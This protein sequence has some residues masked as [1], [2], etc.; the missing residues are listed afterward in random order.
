MGRLYTYVLLL[1]LVLSNLTFISATP[2]SDKDHDGIQDYSDYCPDTFMHVQIDENGCSWIQTDADDDGIVNEYDKCPESASNDCSPF[3]WMRYSANPDSSILYCSF[4]EF[5]SSQIVIPCHSHDGSHGAGT[6]GGY[7]YNLTDLTLD[8]ILPRVTKSSYSPKSD[9]LAVMVSGTQNPN[10]KFSIYEATNLNLLGEFSANG[11]V[12]GFKWNNSGNDVLIEINRGGN[13]VGFVQKYLVETNEII[14]LSTPI[15]DYENYSSTIDPTSPSASLNWPRISPNGEISY[16]LEEEEIDGAIYPAR[17]LVLEYTNN[18]STEVFYPSYRESRI[19][20]P[21]FK[22]TSDIFA[23]LKDG[24][25]TTGVFEIYIGDYDNDG[26]NFL[27]DQCF[28]TGFGSAVDVFGCST[29]QLDSDGDLVPNSVDI[30]PETIHGEYV[31]RFGCSWSESDY[32]VDGYENRIDVCPRFASYS[33]DIN[34]TIC[35]HSDYWIAEQIEPR[36]GVGYVYEFEISP[37]NRYVAVKDGSSPLKWDSKS[38]F[39]LLSLDSM[40]YMLDYDNG[41]QHLG[42]SFQFAK[43]SSTLYVLDDSNLKIYDM[44]DSLWEQNENTI[45]LNGFCNP[46]TCNFGQMDLTPN[47]SHLLLTTMESYEDGGEDNYCGFSMLNLTSFQFD[48][49][50]DMTDRNRFGSCYVAPW[51]SSNSHG[52]QVFSLSGGYGVQIHNLLTTN[53]TSLILEEIV[54]SDKIMAHSPNGNYF[55]H[56]ADGPEGTF[57]HKLQVRY[58]NNFTLISEQNFEKSKSGYFEFSPDSTNLIIHNDGRYGADKQSRFAISTDG[59]LIVTDGFSNLTFYDFHQNLTTNFE[60]YSEQM[61]AKDITI[62]RADRDNDVIADIN[63]AFPNDPTEWSDSDGDGAGDNADNSVEDDFLI[64]IFGCLIPL[65]I[66]SSIILHKPTFNKTVTLIGKLP[67]TEGLVDMLEEQ[68][69]RLDERENPL[70]SMDTMEGFLGILVGI[71]VAPWIL[72][73]YALPFL[74]TIVFAA[75]MLYLIISA[76]VLFLLGSAACFIFLIPF[77]LL[78]SLTG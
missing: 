75:V 54:H 45:N 65:L 25:Q 57:E 49:N 15:Q 4:P 14:D 77:L 23:A 10:E 43:N 28:H 55:A 34:Q 39:F 7:V 35:S 30:C 36:G 74:L 51:I 3:H 58:L 69:N 68:R 29:H 50:Y 26:V 16:E 63:D 59:S 64:G 13:Y 5:T 22:H 56:S 12:I 11:S 78:G 71:F 52:T 61:D 47:G 76:G 18:N 48:L 42:D 38:N 32:D 2:V 8:K 40:S 46:P 37:D 20:V 70:D 9:L 33:N 67:L 53:D 24:P 72:I 41:R 31:D 66:C 27:E 60:H 19:N 6:M 17:R 44:I 21:V 62:L 73:A 1:C